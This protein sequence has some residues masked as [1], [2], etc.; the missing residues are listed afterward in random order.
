MLASYVLKRQTLLPK[1]VFLKESQMFQFL[2]VILENTSIPFFLNANGSLSGMRQ[3][4][5]NYMRFI[6]SWVFGLEVLELLGVRRAF[7]QEFELVTL[8]G[9]TTSF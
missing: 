3:E 2:M 6:R 8:I 4:T 9:L 7:W 5:T 1:L